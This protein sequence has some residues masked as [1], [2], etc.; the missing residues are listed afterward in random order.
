VD[1]AF[2]EIVAGLG[3]PSAPPEARAPDEPRKAHDRHDQEEPAQER[4]LLEGLDTFGADLPD[5]DPGE[6]VPPDPPPVPRPSLPTALGVIGVVGG[7]ALF[8]KPDLLS[9]LAESLAMFLGFT[10]VV[11]GFATLVWRLRPGG[12]D[13][14]PDPDQGARV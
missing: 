13:D 11:T 1:R 8:L 12:D 6:F 2:A 14:E 5:E 7:L 4:S 10:A 9:F 3:H